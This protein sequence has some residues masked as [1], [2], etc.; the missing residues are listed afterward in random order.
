MRQSPNP[1]PRGSWIVCTGGRVLGVLNRNLVRSPPVVDASLRVLVIIAD[2]SEFIRQSSFSVQNTSMSAHSAAASE[3]PT[4][5]RPVGPGGVASRIR[6]PPQR[7]L[8]K[9]YTL[10]HLRRLPSL[11]LRRQPL[12]P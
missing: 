7:A 11:Y 12:V 8:L 1:F 3:S 10:Q 5:P 6:S 2:D 4:R 9:P